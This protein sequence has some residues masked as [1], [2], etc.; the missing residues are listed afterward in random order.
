MCGGGFQSKEIK[1]WGIFFPLRDSQINVSGF[2]GG[3]ST[4]Y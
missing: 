3:K 1:L 2:D 4:G